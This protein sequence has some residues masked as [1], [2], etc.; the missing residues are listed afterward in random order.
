M[1]I[2]DFDMARFSRIP[3]D[4]GLCN[5]AVRIDPAIGEAEI[6]PLRSTLTHAN[7]CITT[8]D[9]STSGVRLRPRLEVLG[10]T[11]M[12]VSEN[13]MKN[14]AVVQRYR[15]TGQRSALLLPGSIHR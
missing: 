13:P 11:G 5:R 10:S 14:A 7:G 9:N 6:W 15:T 3:G 2:H 8:I 1:M 4:R 12:A